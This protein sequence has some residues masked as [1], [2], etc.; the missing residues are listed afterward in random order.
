M[1]AIRSYYAAQFPDVAGVVMAGEQALGAAVQQRRVRLL[2]LGLLVDPPEL[3]EKVGGEVGDVLA[4]LVE[5][6]DLD[7]QSYNFV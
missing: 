3:A 1:Y 6:R 7:G 5:R 2:L 4:P